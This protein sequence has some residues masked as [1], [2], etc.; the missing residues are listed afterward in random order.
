MLKAYAIHSDHDAEGRCDPTQ[1][2]LAV[3]ACE[4]GARQ[5]AGRAEHG[6]T[7]DIDPEQ[8]GPLSVAD[9]CTLD[10][11]LRQARRR[12][13]LEEGGNHDYHRHDAEVVGAQQPG[14][15]RN[16]G[17]ANDKSG[18]LARQFRDAAA[19]GA[20]FEIIHWCGQ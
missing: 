7:A 1:G 17:N 3:K 13:D 16:A 8:I 4:R 14:Q 6:A 2:R 10:H 9:R 11:G 18:A 5:E 15:D 19:N 20:L 12:E